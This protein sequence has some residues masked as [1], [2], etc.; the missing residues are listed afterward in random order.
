VFFPS[1][2]ARV[3]V[4][5]QRRPQMFYGARRGMCHDNAFTIRTAA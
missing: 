1:K 3:G 4:V 5:I 2:N